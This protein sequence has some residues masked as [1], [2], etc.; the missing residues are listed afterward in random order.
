MAKYVGKAKTRRTNRRIARLR[1]ADRNAVPH[2]KADN[3]YTPREVRRVRRQT[4]ALKQREAAA[5]PKPKAAP[6]NPLAPL[7]GKAYRQEERAAERLQYGGQQAELSKQLR[8]NQQTAANTD[9]YYD[10]Y[11]QALREATARINESN[12]QNVEAQQ[13]QSN[14]A[15]T[16][17]SA[18][19]KAR[20]AAAA[21]QAAKFGRPAEASQEGAQAV[22]AQRSQEAQSIAR[23]RDRGTADTSYMEN[24]GAN[25]VLAKAE[26]VG[27]VDTAR[28]DLERKQSQLKADR[29]AFRTKYRADTRESERTYALASKEFGL[30]AADL[31]LQRKK[32]NAQIKN[33]KNKTAAQKIVANIYA[34]ADKAKARAQIRVAKI[35]LQKGR[36]D[37][38]QYRE[39][40]NIYKGLPAKGTSPAAKAKPLTG[41]QEKTVSEAFGRLKKANISVT[42]RKA[43]IDQL[44]GKYGY[45]PRIAREAWRR[46]ER[47]APGSNY[48]KGNVPG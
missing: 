14:A 17:D 30:K 8:G 20:D 9:T 37:R 6:Y 47:R 34:S 40:V 27:R 24:K 48:D 11:R 33:D 28:R 26:A 36:I 12:R 3:R 32:T 23:T 19:L 38:H 25:A 45:P 29:G 44:I 15:Y 10:D 1:L 4:S 42:Q 5:R 31:K 21:A 35:Q 18:G 22:S 43:A 46:W 13:A 39:I 41:P 2:I 7:R 16:E